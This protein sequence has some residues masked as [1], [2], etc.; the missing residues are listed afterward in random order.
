M[1]KQNRGM[2]N[3]PRIGG[4]RVPDA[5]RTIRTLLAMQHPA[6]GF[7]GGPGQFAHLLPTYAAVCS[8]AIVG[9]PGEGGGWDDID[10]FVHSLLVCR[11]ALRAYVGRQCMISSCRL[12]SRMARSSY[13]TMLKSMFGRHPPFR[14]YRDIALMLVIQWHLLP[15]YSCYAA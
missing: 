6:G 7:G 2:N 14:K 3:R 1:T 9:R 10:R 8:L 12:S 13:L 11:L 5:I 15:S 4:I